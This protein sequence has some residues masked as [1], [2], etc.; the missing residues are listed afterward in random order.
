MA[1]IFFEKY[2]DKKRKKP[3]KTIGYFDCYRRANFHFIA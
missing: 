1:T 3:V 2:I